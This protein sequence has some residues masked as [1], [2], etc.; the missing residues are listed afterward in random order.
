MTIVR[1]C[2]ACGRVDTQRQWNSL[3]H[4][5]VSGATRADWVCPS[6]DWPDFDLVEHSGNEHG[7]RVGLRLSH[8]QVRWSAAR[9]PARSR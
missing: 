9:P 6:C 3:D 4:A 8:D 1:R 7:G 2:A 5:A